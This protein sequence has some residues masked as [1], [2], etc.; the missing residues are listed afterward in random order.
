MR[1][2]LIALLGIGLACAGIALAQ[3]EEESGRFVR[4]V[5]RQISTPDRQ[6]DLG[7]ID[8]ALSSDVMI[9]YITIADREG[10]WLRVEDVHL[11]WSRLAL[12]RGRLD[13]DLLEADRILISRPP[14]PA[15]DDTP[16]EPGAEEFALPDL[17]VAIELDRLAVERIEIAEG[18]AG[19]AAALSI[20]GSVELDD[21]ALDTD[22]AIERID[23]PGSLTLD[24]SFDN[25]SRQLA[26]DLDLTEPEGGVVA[27]ALNIEG[28]PPIQLTVAGEGP[29]SDY[30]AEIALVADGD[31]LLS[32]TTEIEG[33]DDG[34][35]LRANLSGTLDRLVPELYEPFVGGGSELVVDAVRRDDGSIVVSEGRLASGVATLAFSAALA[36]D[37]VPTALT[38]DGTLRREDGTPIPLPGGGGESTIGSATIDVALGGGSDAFEATI[39]L[40]DLDTSLI[41]APSVAIRATGEAANLSDPATRSVTFAVDGDAEGLGSDRAGIA[42]A[43]GSALAIDASGSWQA[44]APVTVDNASVVTDTVEARFAGTVGDA[45]DGTYRLAAEDLS[46]FAA[47]AGRPLDGGADLDA[48]GTIGF[49]G[50]FDLTVDGEANDL[51]L[52][53]AAADGLLAGQTT[54]DGR[55]AN[56]EAGVV[57]EDFRLA[58][59]QLT[60]SAD[61]RVTDAEASLTAEVALADLGAVEDAASGPVA[62]SLTVTGAP[63]APSVAA[64]V[65]SPG[66]TVQDQRIDD[67]AVAFDGTL[68]R[69]TEVALDLDGQ[70][71]VD[72]TLDG[73]P[74][75][76]A[77]TLATG[78]DA[79]ALQD[80]SAE[81]AGARVAGDAALLATGL[82]T[83][84]LDVDVPDLGRLAALALQ[85]ASG[86]IDAEVTLQ[87]SEGAQVVAVDGTVRDLS[88]AGVTLAEADADI[89]VDD[90][91]GVPALDGR[92][93][94]RGLSAAGYDVPSADL[95]AERQ[96]ATTSLSLDA[97]LGSGV[98]SAAGDLTRTDA[99]FAAALSSFRL[100]DRGLEARLAQ[101]TTVDVSGQT[102]VVGATRLTI[103]DGTIVV[104]GTFGDTLDLTAQ[105]QDLP[106]RVANL[107]RPSLE[108]GGVVS[109]TV[110]VGGTR[111][112]PTATADV[113]AR[114]VT[115]AL[116]AERG[117]EPL[118]VVARGSYA[119]GT[120]TLERF[121][122]NVGGGAIEASGTVGEALDLTAS[123]RDLPLA[124]ANAVRPE[125]E[126]S[127]TLSGEATVNGSLAEP[128]AT[129]DVRVSEAD[130]A[131]LRAAELEPLNATAVG[132]YAD[133][134]AQLDTFRTTVGGG[135]VTAS[136]SIGESLDVTAEVA[137][138]PLAL[139]EA[140]RPDLDATGTL[141]GTVAAQGTLADPRATFDVTVDD[142]SVAALRASGVPALDAVATGSFAD[143]TARLDRV[144]ASV[145][146]GRLTASGTVGEALDLDVAVDALPLALADAVAPDL[147]LTGTLSGEADL[148]GV[149]AD[150][151]A[152][153]SVRVADA[154]ARR[155]DGTG[156]GAISAEVAGRYADG[157][158]TLETAEAAIG[159]GAVRA[160]GT[161]GPDTL[162]VTAE[163]DA[164]PLGIVNAVRPE[165]QVSGTLSGRVVAT[166]SPSDPRVT[167]EVVAP[168]VT[169]QPIRD[170]GLP[171]AAIEAD[172]AFAD[173][174]VELEDARVRLGGGLVTA[175]GRVGE[176]LDVDLTVTDLPL[177]LANGVRP[178]LGITGTLS[179]T[180]S[181]SGS[182][183]DPQARFD[184]AARGV[185]AAPLGNVGVDPVSID[186]AG[187]FA[188]GAVELAS[189]RADGG[190]LDVAASGTVPLSGPGLD[191]TVDATAPLS[192]ADRFLIE[193]GASLDG[194][195][196][197]RARAT[198]SL[199]DPQ[200]TG[201]LSAA[202]VSF[203]D[204]QSNLSLTGA[205]LDASLTGDRVVIDRLTATLGEG[206]VS[207]AG[208]IGLGDGFP[209]DLTVTARNARYADGRLIAVTFDASLTV[210]G[211]LA[212]GPT[213]AGNVA[214]D[215]AEISVPTRL[216]GTAA[217]LEVAHIATPP[218]VLE[219]L[220]R[221]DAGPFAEDPDA[222]GGDGASGLTL[223]V[224]IDA[225][226]RVFIRGRGIDAE[227]GG[228]VRLT[229]PISDVSPVG[230]FELI[231]GRVVILTQRIELTEGEVTLFGDLN[232]IIRLVAETRNRGVTVRV[233]VDGPARDPQIRFESDPDLPQD[234]VLAQLIFGRSVADLSPFQLA[235][236]AAAVA[237][238]AGAGSGPSIIDQVRAFSGLD[239]LEIIT[240]PSGGTA[241]E[242][243]RYIADNV[244][245]GVRAGPRSTGVTVNLDLTRGLTARA[246]AFTDEASVGLYYEREY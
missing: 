243:G 78:P 122:T 44:G 224:T 108:A 166:G 133:G 134:T 212:A 109:G 57:F 3:E 239:N 162:D 23:R 245:V 53:V 11:V 47:L 204:P 150:P 30:V 202:N 59:P 197:V 65:T 34:L 67:L 216:S 21:G 146:E 28:R 33:V 102:I 154:S 97:D 72:G 144:E 142:A 221:A 228:R 244:Y 114:D 232:P 238:L 183:A 222:N 157:V 55:A 107:V 101:P 51:A 128:S 187:T 126:A 219:T 151:S 31:T 209:A 226:R 169:A 175:Q 120:A 118:T 117:I 145:G 37:G 207:V 92:A 140:V 121:S 124:L 191:V 195:A 27:S 215:R 116:L 13:V 234:E 172:G 39:A 231:R 214:V 58:N 127:G 112:D 161:V 69:T 5:E 95:V 18:I 43:L 225:P 168:E 24:A 115:A 96:G 104:E 136:G 70:L 68:D 190:G 196:T 100:A 156:V 35:R 198:G 9:E 236:L 147:G 218:D 182:L 206:T 141:S 186:V 103:G 223:D 93:S 85:E 203:T 185:S 200:I 240:T 220:R 158:A 174:T 84:N 164:L 125:L 38:V 217:L 184:L 171:P 208:S 8:G 131:P 210:T 167:F 94:L 98:L 227:L 36:P 19:P 1:R 192:L 76:V 123:V 86:A 153:F 88:V 15:E 235:Q 193:R 79:R 10:V 148:T 91:F 139:V 138:L 56:T 155:L 62:A 130:A 132:R 229:G 83:G 180:A 87:A 4:F 82:V 163:L 137:D 211:P 205:S 22:V 242:A 80:L 7:P 6:I 41:A 75:A 63:T 143:G 46:A 165:L 149:L 99:G 2:I 54:L 201:D 173:G 233:V 160:S 77:A 14:L 48:R 188:D 189:L 237:E 64:R 49:D 105:L 177:G 25:D 61:G 119:D 241:V 178:G 29:L 81:V 45:L 73:A 52:G 199:A 213:I 230:R 135:T 60:V 152:T 74:I 20:N 42:D 179:G 181:A 89:V 66:I 113:E 16:I 246:E 194:T 110:E 176:A 12:V 71:Q 129:F 26:I 50:T 17:P 159:T 40:T 106:L 111:E 90:A 170:A 32:G